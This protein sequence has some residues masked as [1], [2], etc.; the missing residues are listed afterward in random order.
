[1]WTRSYASTRLRISNG[2]ELELSAVQRTERDRVAVAALLRACPVADRIR[3]A[4][5]IDVEVAAERLLPRCPLD[6]ALGAAGPRG[7]LAAVVNANAI[8]EEDGTFEVAVLVA[9][10]WRGHG[11]AETL[12]GAIAVLL[13][14]SATALGVIDRDNTAAFSLLRLAPMAAITID[15]DSVT[16]RV[17]VS[18]C[19]ASVRATPKW[20][21]VE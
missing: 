4:G 5:S 9:S 17:P 18:D 8:A 16:F 11:V 12:L 1:M 14:N 6:V 20:L 3:R 13:P 10:A 7:V 2:C 15:P 21:L 19:T